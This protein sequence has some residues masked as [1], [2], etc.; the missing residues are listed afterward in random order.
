M[1]FNLDKK[2][3]PIPT[4]AESASMGHDFNKGKVPNDVFKKVH[5]RKLHFGIMNGRDIQAELGKI[6]KMRVQAE[7]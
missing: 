6:D 1:K 4:W 3:K 7:N 5:I 2:D